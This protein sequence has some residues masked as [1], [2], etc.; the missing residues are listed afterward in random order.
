[1]TEFG[2]PDVVSFVNNTMNMY[3]RCLEAGDPW[4]ARLAAA[5]AAL[6]CH[7]I[8]QEQPAGR[9]GDDRSA[10]LLLGI[11]SAAYRDFA[12]CFLLLKKPALKH[13]EIEQLWT[14]LLDCQERIDAVQGLLGGPGLDW[15]VSQASSAYDHFVKHFGAGDCFFSPVIIVKRES[16]SICGKD[17]RAC[18]HRA[19]V[20]YDGKRC[21]GVVEDMELRSCDLV[22]VPRDRRCRLWPWNIDAQT[23][24][25]SAA[26]FTMFDV[27][28]LSDPLERAEADPVE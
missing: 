17:L 20:I 28:D 14:R 16:C 22:R 18:V 7:S 24:Q 25:F 8:L 23:R 15:L 13:K 1:V 5:S 3:R 11:L 26:V 2:P 21:R 27:D 12:D 10:V 6:R 19:G 4:Q 9:S